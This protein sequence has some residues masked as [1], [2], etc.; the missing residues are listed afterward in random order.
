MTMT[1]NRRLS[2]RVIRHTSPFLCV[3]PASPVR[4]RAPLFADTPA[5]D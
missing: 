4:V 5:S 1:V 3:P 2:P